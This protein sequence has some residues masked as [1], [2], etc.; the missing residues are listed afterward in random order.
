MFFSL[1]L[2]FFFFFTF[3]WTGNIFSIFKTCLFFGPFARANNGRGLWGNENGKNLKRIALFYIKSF[4]VYT[5]YSMNERQSNNITIFDCMKYTAS[6]HFL[7]EFLYKYFH[8]IFNY[9]VEQ[10]WTRALKFSPL[11]F[12]HFFRFPLNLSL[13]L[14]GHRARRLPGKP[15]LTF[16][17]PASS[18][19]GALA[20]H[21]YAL[22]ISKP[23]IRIV[24]I[25]FSRS[26]AWVRLGVSLAW[27]FVFYGYVRILKAI[28]T[29]QEPRVE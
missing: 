9:E 17:I 18:F 14:G 4:Y 3:P 27:V 25:G 7:C 8:L 5:N 6:V 11:L 15:L 29:G 1:R 21:M 26:W 13:S 12:A 20:A 10:R 28:K 2:V 16:L 22:H 24:S 23:S 19:C